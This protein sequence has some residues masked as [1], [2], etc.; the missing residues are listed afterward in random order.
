MTYDRTALQNELIRDE[1]IRLSA[2]RDSLGNM[3]IGVGHLIVKG[4]SFTKI[5]NTEA[6]DILEN[7]ISIAERRLTNIFPSWRSL[8]EVRKRAMLNLTFNLG[9]KL[10]DFKR[11]LHAAKAEDWE[12][13]AD[14]LM[15]SR[16]YKQVKL[17]GPR[18]VHAI[19][20]GTE[21]SGV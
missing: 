13:A 16:W 8:D 14:Q 1:G 15:Q 11:F 19:R 20:T 17:R 12:K 10:A 18:I 6:L 4:E 5:S 3:T 21:W 9:Y 7:D 2:Y